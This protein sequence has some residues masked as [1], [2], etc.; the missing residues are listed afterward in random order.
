[1]VDSLVII[2]DFIFDLLNCRLLF[3]HGFSLLITSCDGQG[4]D[5]PDSVAVKR[6]FSLSEPAPL[7]LHDCGFHIPHSMK[8]HFAVQKQ[9]FDGVPCSGV[10]IH[11]SIDLHLCGSEILEAHLCL[12]MIVEPAPL[13][14]HDCGHSMF[15]EIQFFVFWGFIFH[16]PCSVEKVVPGVHPSSSV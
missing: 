2:S 16:V 9:N 8:F 12:S 14:V 5:H 11:L 10:S 1:M 4:I 15:H 3:L 13:L 7:W 6:K